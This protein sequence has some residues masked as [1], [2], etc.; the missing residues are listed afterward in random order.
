M[1]YKTYA[2][3]SVQVHGVSAVDK[4]VGDTEADHLRDAC[5]GVV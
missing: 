3:F 2:A 1:F 4:N 5:P